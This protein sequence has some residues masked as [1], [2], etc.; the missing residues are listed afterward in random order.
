VDCVAAGLADVA[1]AMPRDS[2][3]AAARA[4]LEKA[5]RDL[6]ALAQENR[7]TSLPRV[8]AKRGDVTTS[9]PLAAVVPSPAVASAADAIVAEAQTVLLRSAPADAAPEYNRISAALDSSRVL[10]RSS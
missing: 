10:L 7:D 8:T 3:Q 4:A 5:S 2:D 1:A 6:R 9:R